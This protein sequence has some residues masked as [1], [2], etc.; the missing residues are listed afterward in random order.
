MCLGAATDSSPI[1]AGL[2]QGDSFPVLY[3]YL[4]EGWC[5]ITPTLSLRGGVHLLDIRALGQEVRDILGSNFS[6]G[7]EL[8]GY[9][10]F[11]DVGLTWSF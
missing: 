6:R 2:D 9:V 5:S 8:P 4:V 3:R 7:S 10:R 1:A 11:L